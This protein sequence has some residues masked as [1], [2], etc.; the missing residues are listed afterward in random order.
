MK[1]L[2]ICKHVTFAFM[3]GIFGFVKAMEVE[4]KIEETKNIDNK[5]WNKLPHELK[6]RIMRLA[7]PEVEQWLHEKHKKTQSLKNLNEH[8]NALTGLAI[9]SDGSKIVSA[10]CDKKLIIWNLD[11]G[12]VSKILNGHNNVITGL[13][14]APDGSKIISGDSDG[15]VIIWGMDSGQMQHDFVAH[16]GPI[17]CL[18]I[19]CDDLRDDLR[20]VIPF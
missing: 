1:I 12:K 6:L 2:N 3:V 7:Y 13:V 17:N 8:T 10:A 20:I 5:S 11:S 14:V 9:T 16:S 15:K 18:S 4:S 19:T